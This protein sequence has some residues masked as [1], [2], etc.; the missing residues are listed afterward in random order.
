MKITKSTIYYI[1]EVLDAQRNNIHTPLLSNVE[2]ASREGFYKGHLAM[3]EALLSNGFVDDISIDWN[4][5]TG[6][7]EIRGIDL[8]DMED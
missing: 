5:F 4:D 6:Y 1:L 2:Y 3:A 7:H 8:N